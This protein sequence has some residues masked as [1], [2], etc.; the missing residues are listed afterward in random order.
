M[1][2]VEMNQSLWGDDVDVSLS[3]A[4]NGGLEPILFNPE[5][6]LRLSNMQDTRQALHGKEVA[7]DLTHGE[8]ISPQHVADRLGCAFELFRDLLHRALHKFFSQQFELRLSPASVVYREL[9]EE[10]RFVDLASSGGLTH[11]GADGRLLTGSYKVAQHWSAALRLHPA[12]PDGI[13]Y[14]SRHDPTR[15]AYAIFTRPPSTFKVTSMGPL[16]AYAN[17]ALL[18]QLLRDYN[19]DLI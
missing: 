16:T 17:R 3:P 9:T 10:L 1:V 6:N 13:R 2:F 15:V 18:N 14:L 11:V 7:A 8:I 12:K 5:D 19:V 4:G